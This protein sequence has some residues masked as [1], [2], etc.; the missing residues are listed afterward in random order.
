MFIDHFAPESSPIVP[1]PAP[2]TPHTLQTDALGW[3][4]VAGLGI[5]IAISGQFSGWNYGLSTG[6]WGGLVVAA[7]IT[8]LFYL[9][10][11]QCVA[12]LAAAM[13]TAGG[14][15]TYC[16]KAF[17]TSAGYLVGMSVLIALAIAVGVVANFT[18]AYGKAVLGIGEVPLKIALFGVVLLLQLR[19]A[20][21]AVG[22]TMV[23]GLTAVGVLLLFAACMAPFVSAQHL[24]PAQEHDLFPH[25]VGG[26]FASLPFALWLFLGVEQ[27]ALAAE[28]AADPSRTIPKALTIAVVTLLLVGLGVLFFGPAGGGTEQLRGADDPL[29]A[30]LTSPFAYGKQGWLTKTIGSGALIGLVATFFSVVYTSSRQLYSLARDGYLPSSL[31]AT[32]SK[33][34]PHAALAV[35]VG[36]GI[37]AA[38]FPPAKAMLLVIFLLCVSYVFVLAAFV[39]LRLRNAALP[40][41]YRAFGGYVT[42]YATAA[43]CLLVLWACFAQ[44]STGMAYALVVYALLLAH[45]ILIQRR[46]M[47]ARCIQS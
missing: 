43:V 3:L 42:A 16:R 13:P 35:V 40:R 37:L 11:T 12:E 19:G 38:L 17:G 46:K 28:E 23:V 24:L 2:P 21:E 39:R 33:Q 6:G 4:K 1:A 30:A 9:G 47:P 18:A 8:G 25:G 32:N 34:A 14:F 20:R 10:F 26:V 36:I 44:Q 31:A 15:E 41:P 45:F 22:A 27:A 7:L 5:A 29:Y